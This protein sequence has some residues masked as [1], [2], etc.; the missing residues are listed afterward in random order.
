MRDRGTRWLESGG[1]LWDLVSTSPSP[2][3][4][5]LWRAIASL[6]SFNVVISTAASGEHRPIA[7][8][9]LIPS[10][11]SRRGTSRLV[12]CSVFGDCTVQYTDNGGLHV[13]GGACQVRQSNSALTPPFRCPRC[14]QRSLPPRPTSAPS[15]NTE[16]QPLLHRP[17]LMRNWRGGSG[18]RNMM[19]GFNSRWNFISY[20]G[21]VG[22][23]SEKVPGKSFFSMARREPSA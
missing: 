5:K 14:I 20:N 10:S 15:L 7:L 2:A 23:I 16:P 12:R 13:R 8:K 9:Y 1:A 17:M 22:T 18:I 11:S 4:G 6:S 21:S 19:A 3:L